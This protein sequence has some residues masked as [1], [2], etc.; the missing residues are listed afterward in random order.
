[1]ND[2][3]LNLDIEIYNKA[4]DLEWKKAKKEKNLSG[5]LKICSVCGRK[6]VIHCIC[7]EAEKQ[8][9]R[10]LEEVRLVSER[11]QEEAGKSK[12]KCF[13]NNTFKGYNPVGTAAIVWAESKE[14]AVEIFNEYLH[15]HTGLDGDTLLEDMIEF[16]V[17]ELPN[18]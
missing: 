4:M 17:D 1:M 13:Y 3:V 14:E 9:E 7:P 2:S 15:K 16:P 12:R 6:Y 8:W 5:D 11:N 18:H 10:S